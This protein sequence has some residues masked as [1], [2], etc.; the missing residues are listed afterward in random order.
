VDVRSSFTFFMDAS[1]WED[2]VSKMVENL[3]KGTP[4]EK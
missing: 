4:L 2:N 3:I 1:N